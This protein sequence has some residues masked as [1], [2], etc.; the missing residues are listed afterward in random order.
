MASSYFALVSNQSRSKNVCPDNLQETPNTT[1][2][3]AI[4]LGITFLLIGLSYALPIRLLPDAASNAMPG[5]L[6]PEVLNVYAC[7]AWAGW[8][9][10][11]FA[12]RGQAFGL[13]K[14]PFGSKRDAW[15]VGAVF[16]A[17]SALIS[18]RSL[19][20]VS[21]FGTLVWVYFID[22]FL[23]SEQY[24]EAPQEI[25]SRWRTSYR[26]VL[27]FAWVSVVLL[28]IGEI[29]SRRWT[30]IGVSIAVAFVVLATGGWKEFREGQ[31]RGPLLSFF[32]IGEALVWGI[33]SAYSGPV[34]RTGVYIFHIAAASYFH[35]IGSYLY[36]VEHS[37]GNDRL[38]GPVGIIALNLAVI[39]VGIAV[40]RIGLL[41]WLTPIVGIQWFTLWV[42][43][44][45]ISSDPFPIFKR[46]KILAGH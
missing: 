23:K 3:P 16:I 35:Y 9:H 32:F 36:A 4:A 43:L 46:S 41:S 31:V 11:V 17:L 30:L 1:T 24:F 40:G 10:F 2:R 7:V 6:P 28:N 44:H 26:P 19:V 20:G 5:N 39:V 33:F 18:L 15:F 27:A 13:R 38:L 25:S 29:D 34:F 42:G 12:F 22:H 14:L 45:L 21:L 8:A 37:R